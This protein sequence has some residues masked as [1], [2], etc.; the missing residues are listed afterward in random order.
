MPTPTPSVAGSASHPPVTPRKF[1]RILVA[2]RSEIAIRVFRACSELGIRTLGIVS[3]EDKA[4]LHRYKADETYLL[5][6][7]GGPRAQVG[8]IAAYLDIENIVA[9]ARRH[10][11]E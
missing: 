6:E 4:A 8:A 10:G 9:I 1:H 7:A 3:K 11:A 2:N 5:N